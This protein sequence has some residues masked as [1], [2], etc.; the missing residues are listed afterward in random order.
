M[1]STLKTTTIGTD[2]LITAKGPS[3]IRAFNAKRVQ[4]QQ[5][6]FEM[7]ETIGNRKT[8]LYKQITLD[9]CKKVAAM[10]VK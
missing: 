10:L 3:I 4:N 5:D 7:S 2:Y 8:I 1:N 6:L 9:K